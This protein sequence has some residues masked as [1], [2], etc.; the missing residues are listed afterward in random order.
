MLNKKFL[1]QH[2]KEL[3]S[4]YSLK[5][6]EEKNIKIKNKILKNHKVLKS[7]TIWFFV[8]WKFE[9]DTK[10]IIEELLKIWKEIY[11]PKVINEDKMIF[12]KIKSL[13]DLEVWKFNI[14]EPKNSQEFSYIEAF[15]VPWLAFTK[16]WKRLWKGKWYYDKYFLVNKNNFKIW[17]CFDFQ[18]F[19]DF[20]SH[21][22]DIWMDEVIF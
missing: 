4:K 18:I 1:R 5:E 22:F 6:L 19:E 7:K 10:E 12:C 15:L 14:L 16:S 17:V 11:L 8:W 13:N 3:F 20:E 21:E 9:V 2:V